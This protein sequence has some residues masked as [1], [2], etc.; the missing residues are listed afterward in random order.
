M[1]SLSTI[2]IEYSIDSSSTGRGV[3]LLCY[4]KNKELVRSLNL[5][6]E[7]IL[8]YDVSDAHIAY[9]QYERIHDVRLY[10]GW[11]L[12]YYNPYSTVL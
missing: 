3:R 1:H 9:K 4:P 7:Y 12:V 8:S 6:C 11:N 5:V 10:G 2:C